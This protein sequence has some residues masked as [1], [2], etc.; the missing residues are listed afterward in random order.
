L[1]KGNKTPEEARMPLRKKPYE[2]NM[3]DDATALNEAWDS[4]KETFF[5]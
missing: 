5:Y 2:P 1:K 4:F 3:V